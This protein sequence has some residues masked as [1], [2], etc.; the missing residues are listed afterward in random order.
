MRAFSKEVSGRSKDTK[1]IGEF[2]GRAR[3]ETIVVVLVHPTALNFPWF[4]KLP[5]DA[6]LVKVGLQRD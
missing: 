2:C 4:F 1:Q 5:N 6:S 3:L